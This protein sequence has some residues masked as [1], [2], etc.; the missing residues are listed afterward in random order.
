MS[1]KNWLFGSEEPGR[2]TPAKNR[3]SPEPE[4]SERRENEGP[5]G[6]P[7]AK[8]APSF[9]DVKPLKESE[10]PKPDADV[11]HTQIL[12]KAQLKELQDQ[13]R[14]KAEPIKF[15]P[16]P[17]KSAADKPDASNKAGQPETETPSSEPK[18]AEAQEPVGEPRPAP[19]KA[20]TWQT[21]PVAE[22]W[23]PKAVA[24]AFP[25]LDRA[26]HADHE[27]IERILPGGWRLLGASRRGRKQA[28]DARFREDAM[29]FG[30][31]PNITVLAVADGAG[32]SR[33]SRIGSHVAVR[34]TVRRLLESTK[35]L[36]ESEQ[37]DSSKLETMLK[38]ALTAAVKAARQR[39]IDVAE[40]ASLSPKEFRSTLLTVLHWRDA[41]N[42]LLLSNQVGDGAI[43]V[44]QSDQTIRKFGDADSGA[45]SGEVSCFLTDEEAARKAD[46][47][48]SITDVDRVEALLLCSDGIEDP[49]YPIDKKALDI[50]RQWHT[51]VTEPLDG[52][53]DQP[54][55]GPVFEAEAAAGEFAR[56]LEF[57]KRGEND[58]RTVMA[59]HRLPTRISF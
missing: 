53:K 5:Q 1:L 15:V 16:P 40:K 11:E 31:L 41:G 59:L 34:E 48:Q 46:N 23:A 14:E 10:L 38:A 35:A 39:V 42:E 26:D 49:F 55:Q 30:S 44:L 57:E 50:F 8:D 33:L 29:S 52:F 13:D 3:P 19:I 4:K 32:S 9:A 54:R 12:T 51:G 6:P 45:F 2:E 20:A 47:I 56:W 28:H 58:D 18:E 37:S 36:A 21:E 24:Q 25:E 43:A 7:K 17:K 22:P 27:T